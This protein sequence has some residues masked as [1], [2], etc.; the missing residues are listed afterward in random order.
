MKNICG[1]LTA[2]LFIS[3]IFGADENPYLKN[4][5]WFDVISVTPTNLI[6]KPKGKFFSIRQNDAW[7]KVESYTEN[8][9]TLI[10]TPESDTEFLTRRAYREILTPVIFKSQHKGFVVVG[11]NVEELYP[12]AT[13]DNIGY[14]VLSEVTQH[15]G[16]DDV[17]MILR[18][19]EWKDAK[20]WRIEE[21]RAWEAPFEE[22]L[23]KRMANKK[24]ESATT[25]L[26]AADADAV[27]PSTSPC[28][29]PSIAAVLV[30]CAGA[31]LHAL[32]R[33]PRK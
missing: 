33:R 2:M 9:E 19:G 21:Q 30:L 26:P 1:T 8:N 5:P 27:P 25:L 18:G 32:T 13:P 28:L 23:R 4:Q 7:R 3:N 31:C 11:R 14:V 22:R 20:G 17:E 24:T 16:E 12:Q 29:L 6:V 10:L 15:V